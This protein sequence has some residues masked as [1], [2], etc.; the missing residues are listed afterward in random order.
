MANL[1]G[2][3]CPL[4][5][6]PDPPV[7]EVQLIPSGQPPAPPSAEVT[8]P[9]AAHATFVLCLTQGMPDR[10]G[11]HLSTSIANRCPDTAAMTGCSM[12]GAL[13]YTCV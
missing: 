11:T 10:P 13:A 2:S 7:A 12:S 5:G 1:L 9:L 3:A 8:C 4:C 6:P